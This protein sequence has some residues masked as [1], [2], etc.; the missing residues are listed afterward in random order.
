[1]EAA[2]AWIPVV[3]RAAHGINA[4]EDG[5]SGGKLRSASAANT[6]ASE[7]PTGIRRSSTQQLSRRLWF[8][9]WGGALRAEAPGRHD[10]LARI[11]GAAP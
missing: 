4:T 2:R 5:R 9:R 8:L 10:G 11:G 3:T 7:A 1:M 6:L